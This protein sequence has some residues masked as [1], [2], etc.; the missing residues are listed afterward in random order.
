MAS[1]CSREQPSS[2]T[3]RMWSSVMRPVLLTVIVNLGKGARIVRGVEGK[4]TYRS[5]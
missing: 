5:P 4:K 3:C 2:K 1:G